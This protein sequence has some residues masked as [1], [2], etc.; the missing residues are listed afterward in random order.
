MKVPKLFL[1][2]YLCGIR[3][4][5]DLF[6]KAVFHSIALFTHTKKNLTSGFQLPDFN[7]KPIHDLLFM[8][9]YL[10]KFF[11]LFG[12]VLRFLK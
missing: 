7:S 3:Y 2:V 8:G 12:L 11:R 6:F 1:L 5:D 4:Q 10:K 9:L